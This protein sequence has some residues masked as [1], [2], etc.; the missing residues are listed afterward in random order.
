MDTISQYEKEE[1]YSERVSRNTPLVNKNLP[2]KTLE[3]R[4]LYKTHPC[5]RGWHHLKYYILAFVILGIT[6]YINFDASVSSTLGNIILTPLTY[7]LIIV[8]FLIIIIEEL[9]KHFT[10]Y[11]VTT[12][13]IV[14]EKGIISKKVD[15]RQFSIIDS[16][17]VKINPL[18]RLFGIG[19]L[20]IGVIENIIVFEDLKNPNAIEDYVAKIISKYKRRHA[21][22]FG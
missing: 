20:E 2:E 10:L 19:D 15:S 14:K 16:I 8:F 4:V 9:K 11:Y 21:S 6:I 17:N 22:G 5:R 13:R 3:E 7:L 1:G 12:S 18:D